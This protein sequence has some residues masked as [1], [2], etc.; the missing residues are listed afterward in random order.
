MYYKVDLSNY[1]PRETRIYLEFDKYNFS[2]YQL[3][4]IQ[5]ELDN[6]KDSYGY[7]SGEAH[8]KPWKNWNLDDLKYR[9]E[10]N[11]TFYL[12]G[13]GRDGLEL[14]AIEGWAF[15]DYNWEIPYLSNRYVVPKYRD[16]K[17]SEDLVWMRLN[18]LKKQGY[19]YCFGHIHKW[20]KPAQLVSRKVKDLVEIN[21]KYESLGIKKK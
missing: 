5:I 11:W 21:E 6:F 3:E 15:I 2:P 18:D 14:P 10:N 19:D 17:L 20:N 7:S 16:R 12:V 13:N 9:L 8:R 1:T 4:S